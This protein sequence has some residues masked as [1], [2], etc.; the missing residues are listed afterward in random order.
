VKR[1][2]IG[3]AAFLRRVGA[4]GAVVLA[5]LLAAAAFLPLRHAGY[6]QDDHL[7]VEKNPVVARGDLVEMF[8]S[9]YWAGA[10]GADK[11]LYRPVAIWS[12]ALERKLVGEPNPA[13]AHAVNVLAHL[14]V[15]L[16]LMALALRLGADLSSAST[17]MLFFAIH[18]LHVEAVGSI[19]ARAEIL[20]AGFS[21]LALWALSHTSDPDG[22]TRRPA[23]ARLAAWGAAAALFLALGSKEVALVTPVLMVLMLLLF[24]GP[25]PGTVRPWLVARF[26]ALAPSAL[27]VE[28]YFVLRLRALEGFPLQAP[29]PLDNHLV[30]LDGLERAGTALGLV[31]RTVWLFV[32]PVRLSIDYSGFVIPPEPGI[33]GLRPLLGL[34]LLAGAAWLAVAA[35]LRRSPPRVSLYAREQRGPLPLVSLAAATF[36]LPY[37][38]VG[39][40]LTDVGTIFAERLLY[41]PSVGVC[42]L[43][44]LGFGWLAWR[45]PAFP[46]WTEV[47]RVRLIGG[48]VT[49]LLG[50]FCLLSWERSLHWR[51]DETIFR[52]A[53]LNQPLS[54][55]AHF[56]V[57]KARLEAGAVDEALEGFR[58]TLELWPTHVPAWLEI[59]LLEG[60][61]GR[62]REAESALRKALEHAPQNSKAR[63]NLGIALHRQGRLREA[64]REVLKA[65]LTRS[66][67]DGE[68]VPAGAKP[69]AELGHLRFETGRFESAAR[70][71]RRAVA[72]G[73]EDLLPRLR[74]AE[75]RATGS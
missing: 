62:F 6:I 54:P 52:S 51:D 30:L 16:M 35:F 4:S 68:A 56:V 8:D 64:E 9:Y 53:T 58:R 10:Q 61:R 13:V 73:R 41:F 1:R 32:A 33:L 31:V 59:G 26:G 37:L 49:I 57:A 43:I 39:N 47:Q 28:L 19:V 38:I 7:A 2:R 24:R 21:L 29:H 63:L 5:L 66:G 75:S 15:A 40:L 72:L 12:F 74:D 60:Q 14:V 65:T 25:R 22:A 42:L 46:H 17:A 69:W 44:G 48:A 20:A 27:A 55:R 11:S 67:P 23:R 45:Y 70:A 50:A 71:Y 36:L 18:P 3:L 34:F